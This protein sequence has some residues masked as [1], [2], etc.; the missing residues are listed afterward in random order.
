MFAL[1]D[2]VVELAVLAVVLVVIL[3]S[4]FVLAAACREWSERRR[5]QES[6]A[7]RRERVWRDYVAACAP[8][9]T[10]PPTVPVVAAPS[11]GAPARA[12][13]DQR[14]GLRAGPAKA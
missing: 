4:A 7:R 11:T 1:Q 2:M 6:R 5:A 3:L 14:T 12:A 13:R 8:A 9:E 10:L